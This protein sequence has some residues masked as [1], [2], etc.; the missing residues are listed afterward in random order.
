[1]PEIPNERQ[2]KQM[3][4]FIPSLAGRARRYAETSSP[5]RSWPGQSFPAGDRVPPPPPTYRDLC[6]FLT[7]QI[8]QYGDGVMYYRPTQTETF[9]SLQ[10][11]IGELER[12]VNSD[13]NSNLAR[14][15]RERNAMGSERLIDGA[16]IP[17]SENFSF[18]SDLL[19]FIWHA[20][21]SVASN[22]TTTCDFSR[23]TI[24]LLQMP[25]GTSAARTFTADNLLHLL[26]NSFFLNTVVIDSNDYG[27]IDLYNLF[28]TI[29]DLGKERI[30]CLLS[31]FFQI[32]TTRPADLA[33]RLVTFERV[34]YPNPLESLDTPFAPNAPVPPP[35]SISIST[36]PMETPSADAFF[37]FA[38]KRVHIHS[39]IPSCTQEEILFS[40]CPESFAAIVLFETL[41]N[42]EVA[43]V[44]GVRRY[45]SYAGYAD[46]FTFVDATPTPTPTTDNRTTTVLIADA[47]YSGH[48]FRD[49]VRRDLAKAYHVFRAACVPSV[50]TNV[51][52]PTITPCT[53][54]STG[55]WGCGVFGGD[56]HHKFVQQVVAFG[57][58]LHEIQPADSDSGSLT[59][60]PGGT[61]VVMHYSVFGERNLADT[62]IRWM[63]AMEKNGVTCAQVEAWMTEYGD[64]GRDKGE[65]FAEFFE[66]KLVTH[67]QAAA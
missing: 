25:A 66:R 32:H 28:E 6:E 62:F 24:S 18:M 26:A 16:P 37:D 44:H 51:T 65:S 30:L 22:T 12:K 56:K 61:G 4:S 11:A 29:D 53:S 40:A 49:R 48:F 47:C 9:P 64:R 14:F 36:D 46:S 23:D 60:R 55:H 8:Q 59:R 41:Q 5:K 67:M 43:L 33:T 52:T 57:R 2:N 34:T 38:N 63:G 31:Y 1:M 19:P 7:W 39:I 3:N 50:P 21:I 58:L 42:N 20:A 27:N 17:H 10:A 45:I 35:S 15:W 13:R 54:I